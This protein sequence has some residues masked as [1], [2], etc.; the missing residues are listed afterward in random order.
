[1]LYIALRARWHTIINK[2]GIGIAVAPLA[3][4]GSRLDETSEPARQSS[5][6]LKHCRV[7]KGALWL[8]NIAERRAGF[9]IAGD[10]FRVESE[11]QPASR[12]AVRRF[13]FAVR[14]GNT[15]LLAENLG[16]G[17]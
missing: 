16:G 7:P 12:L 5:G 1:M 10:E 17:M 3:T 8:S 13:E 15:G 6:A 4:A 14:T 9:S 11:Y 2:D